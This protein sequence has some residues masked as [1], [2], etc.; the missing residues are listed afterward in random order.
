M[1]G[2]ADA[3]S[4]MSSGKRG[5]GI[6]DRMSGDTKDSTSDEREQPHPDDDGPESHLKA[7]HA[8]QG[9]KHVHVHHHEG[10]IT[11]H[12]IKEDGQVEGPHDHENTE[13]LADH[14]KRFLSE[15]A[16]EP[17]SH[18]SEHEGLM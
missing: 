3:I 2:I 11:T 18:D 10:G 6:A 14:M 9:G 1:S 15:E 16:H 13:A 17:A 5:G 7:L 8:K 12:Q 4:K